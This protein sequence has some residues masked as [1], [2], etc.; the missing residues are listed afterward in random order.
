MAQKLLFDGI[1]K[2]IALDKE[3]GNYACFYALSLKLEYITKIVTSGVLACIGDDVDRHRYS[4]EHKLVRANSIGEW[5]KALNE[6][7]VG[8]PARFFD[9]NARKLVVRDLTER[10]GSGDWRYSAVTDL[11][12]AAAK[13]GAVTTLGGKVTLRQFFEIGA[14]FR[15]RSRGHGASTNDQCGQ[16][17]PRLAAA[18]DAVAGRLRLF[19]LPW[20]YLHRNLSGKYRVSSLLGDTS[21]FDYLKSSRDVHLPNGVF[22]YLGRPVHVPLVFSDP[23]VLDIALPN[24]N[25]QKGAFDVLSYV[26]NEV[27]RQDSSVWSLPPAKLPQSETAGDIVLQPFGNTFAN[28]PPRFPDNIPRSDLEDRLQEELLKSDRHPIISLTGAGG[29]GKTTTAIDTIHSIAERDP[30]PYEVI[31]WISARDIDLLE[32]GPKSVSPRAIN[33]RDISRAAVELLEPPGHSSE[34]FEPDVFFQNCLIEG[35][36]GPTLFVLD[37]F[38]TM[39]S[40]ADVFKWIDTYIRP[41]NKVLITTRFRDFAGDYP[42]KIGGMTGEQAALLVDQQAARLNVA[43]LLDSDY[44][45]ELI[46]EADGHPYVIK[47]LL[48][49]VAKERRPVKPQRI[50]ADADDLLKALFERT[51]EALSPGAQRVFL[52][53]CSWRVFVPEVAVVAVSLRPGTKSFPV[54][55]ALEELLRFS[56]VGQ[57]FSKKEKE[58]FV[59][60][61]LAAAMYGRSKLK[62]SPFRVTV[63]EDRKILMEFGAGKQEDVERGVLPRIEN[64]V[65]AVAVRA[66]AS[67]TALKE[68]LPVLEYLAAKVPKAYLRLADLVLEV[69]D[70]GHSTDQAKT[71][72]RNYLEKAPIPDRLNAW[73]RLAVLC[74]SSQDPVG[75]VHALSEAALLPTLDQENL[76]SFA[77]R[78][79]NRMRDLKGCSSADARSGEIRELLERVIREMEKHLQN[80]SATDCSRLAWL[81]LNIDNS[82]RALDVVKVGVERD[83]A[84]EHCQNLILKLDASLATAQSGSD[85]S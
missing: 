55:E 77:N 73:L 47:I 83:P 56:L 29:I 52:L 20:V 44:K 85:S 32:S 42:I 54:T 58:A 64:L 49:Q 21:S 24:G 46:R 23:D 7:L 81:Y 59:G 80:L 75:E 17:C 11:N 60:V 15:N 12:Q 74:Q 57:V 4:L 35:A 2:R 51:Y 41:P 65:Q 40:P 22:L 39:Q 37:N 19:G 69:G 30:P 53:L 48:G 16:S 33:Q 31:L 67:P 28:V 78:L 76:G 45:R 5:A 34:G 36:A 27:V 3:D 66:S 43:A 72:V 13:V 10:V 1:D 62:V 25:C 38:E 18:L 61:P 70:S 50:V 79:N 14:Q 63:E 84:N 82:Q 6:A 8:S 9:S 68:M 26:T 71:Y